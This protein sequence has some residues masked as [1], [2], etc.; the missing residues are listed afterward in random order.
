MLTVKKKIIAFI[1]L[2][3]VLFIAYNYIYKDHRIIEKESPD[4]ILN[5]NS[6][7]QEFSKSQE[8]AESKY[9]DKTIEVIGIVTELNDND[10][11]LDNKVFCKFKN[12]IT[13]I[14][15]NDEVKLK[16]RCIGYDDLL[17]QIK[18]DQCNIME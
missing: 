17:E 9:L 18:F 1:T 16:G 2:A 10:L 6:I 13:K 4:F 14:S 8:I 5:S 7:F 3:L 15:I 12:N 11:T